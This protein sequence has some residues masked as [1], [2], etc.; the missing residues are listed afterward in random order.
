MR[1]LHGRL[2]RAPHPM[3]VL[4]LPQHH[5]KSSAARGSMGDPEISRPRSADHELPRHQAGCR[6]RRW[7][8]RPH[9]DFADPGSSGNGGS[10][11]LLDQLRSDIRFGHSNPDGGICPLDPGRVS[12]IRPGSVATIP[13]QNQSPP[14]ESPR[15]QLPLLLQPLPRELP[16]PPPRLGLAVPRCVR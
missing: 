2:E 13:P 11:T 6:H 16:L 5:S 9:M 1:W 7:S 10:P 12:L 3:D 4:A 14:Q 8:N 15:G